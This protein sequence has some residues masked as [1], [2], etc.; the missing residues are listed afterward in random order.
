MKKYLFAM[1]VAVGLCHAATVPSNGTVANR[2]AVVQS[3]RVLSDAQIERNIRERFAR[4]KMTLV[5]KER[6]TV[7]VQD[8]VAILEGK[9]GVIQHKGVAT[10]IAK[11]GG[12]VAV[13]NHIEVSAEAR[14]KAAARLNRYRAGSAGPVR[15]KVLTVP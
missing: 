2:S 7:K 13:E 12:A 9:T 4:S 14:A 11:M 1:A 3:R 8:G 5:S 15:A 10:R 6:F